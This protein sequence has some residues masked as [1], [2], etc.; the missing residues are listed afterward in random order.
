NDLDKLPL[1]DFNSIDMAMAARCDNKH[2][3]AFEYFWNRLSVDDQV[4]VAVFR[5]DNRSG[6][7]FHHTTVTFE[8]VLGTAK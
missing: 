4:T 2:W 7:F 6:C 5:C 3:T 8:D 1:N